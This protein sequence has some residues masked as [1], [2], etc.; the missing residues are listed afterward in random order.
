MRIEAR[1]GLLVGA[2]V[3]HDEVGVE[4]IVRL[5]GKRP[6]QGVVI[7][8]AAIPHARHDRAHVAVILVADEGEPALQL[9]RE[10]AGHRAV[11]DELTEPADGQVG[12]ALELLASACGR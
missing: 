7:V 12:V 6:A 11:D 10:R 9:V 8:A 4:R 2:H 5:P 3:T 1:L